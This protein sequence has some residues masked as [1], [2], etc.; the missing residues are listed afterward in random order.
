MSA[1]S[2]IPIIRVWDFFCSSLPLTFGC[3]GRT[4][5]TPFFYRSFRPT[6]A[7]HN[8]GGFLKW[9]HPQN[10]QNWN[11]LVLNPWFWGI[12]SFSETSKLCREHSMIASV[13]THVNLSK[14]QRWAVP[15]RNS[16][17][18]V[19]V[20]QP[21]FTRPFMRFLGPIRFNMAQNGSK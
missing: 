12:Q 5:T 11:S 1:R 13:S 8:I 17:N 3:L 19:V 9:W 20:R 10:I 2:K 21:L 15:G 14:T 7:R 6:G 16:S 4:C 18:S